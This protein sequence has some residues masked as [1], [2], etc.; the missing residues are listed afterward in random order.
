MEEDHNFRV[1]RY[2]KMEEEHIG[3][4]AF[5]VSRPNVLSNPFTHIKGKKTK[6]KYVVDTRE[7][8][9]KMY[10]DYFDYMVKHDE[11]F[12]SEFMRII[13]ACRKFDEVYLGCYCHPEKDKCHAEV[14]E[15]RILSYFMKERVA[16]LVKDRKALKDTEEKDKL[17]DR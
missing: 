3:E 15:K 9:V 1:I 8:A 2:C 14:I 13:D 5:D 7:Q 12:R 6:A 16:A 17:K 10:A 11:L 4:N